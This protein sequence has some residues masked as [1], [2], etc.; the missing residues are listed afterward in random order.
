M[1][2]IS[3]VPT[4]LD[5]FSLTPCP[6]LKRR[7]IFKK[8]GRSGRNI[9]TVFSWLTRGKFGCVGGFH[10]LQTS[11]GA[12]AFGPMA[13]SPHVKVDHRRG[14]FGKFLWRGMKA[15]CGQARRIDSIGVRLSPGAAT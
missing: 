12:P 13:Q 11:R 6:A 1:S 3:F 2:A 5:W 8:D 10:F 14:G 7:A 15:T 4:G 9:D